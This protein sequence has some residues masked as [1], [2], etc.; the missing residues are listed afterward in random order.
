MLPLFGNAQDKQQKD[1]VIAVTMQL[2]QF[3]AL[4]FAIDSNIDSKKASKELIEFL[5]QNAK[6][7]SPVKEE[8]A[9]K[10]QPK[11]N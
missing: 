4:L 3:R 5:Q 8:P 2:N 11:K 1:T 6:M 9:K 7:M 10:E